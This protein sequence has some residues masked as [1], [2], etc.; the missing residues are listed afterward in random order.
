MFKKSPPFFNCATPQQA[1][2]LVAYFAE[3][4]VNLIKVYDNIPRDAFFALMEQAR[5]AGIAVAGHKPVR[6]STTEASA[7]GMKSLE[8]ARFLLW[9]S[10]A[11]AAALRNHPDP[12]SL[13][14]TSLRRRLLQSMIRSG[15]W[16]YCEY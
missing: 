7:A 14:N 11:G 9:D 12:Q 8:H 4:K 5:K 2:Q 16:P 15:C 1:K 13:D 6:V 3:R 10:F